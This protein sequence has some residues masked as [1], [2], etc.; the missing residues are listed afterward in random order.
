MRCYAVLLS[1]AVTL[2]LAAGVDARERTFDG[3]HVRPLNQ[4]SAALMADAQQKS[5]TVR[6]LFNKL[7]ASNVVA[8]VHVVPLATGTPESGLRFV[9][10][11]KMARFVL[12]SISG[13][14][15]A[16][17]RIELLGRELQHAVEIAG[18]PWVTDDARFQYLMS[19][20]G[21]Q[22]TSGARR[23]YETAAANRTERQVRL[24]VRG[25]TGTQ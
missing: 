8:Y 18:M 13:D 4:A 19:V 17:R 15:T 16:D 2:T 1:A 6:E 3:P 25:I 24:E 11:S 9:G 10:T 21:W 22:D 20:V 12:I 14:S 7:E 5:A 23:G